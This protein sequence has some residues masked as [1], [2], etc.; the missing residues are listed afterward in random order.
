VE[1]VALNPRSDLVLSLLILINIWLVDDLTTG[2]VELP[3][4]LSSG[5]ELK[6]AVASVSYTCV[7]IASLSCQV[8]SK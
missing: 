3:H 2:G 4:A 5:I 1:Y 7:T 6:C 8:S